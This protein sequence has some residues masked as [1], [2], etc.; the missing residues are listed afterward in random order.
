MDTVNSLPSE[1]FAVV[2]KIDTAS[3]TNASVDSGWFEVGQIGRICALINVGTVAGANSIT[4]SVRRAENASGDNPDANVNIG[5]FAAAAAASGVRIA[6]YD[7]AREKGNPKR[8]LQL[9]IAGNSANAVQTT[10]A[11]LA[12][13]T[14]FKPGSLSNIAAA[15][16]I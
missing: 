13:D 1:R 5:T 3:V 9:R 14:S 12:F 4:V 7:V 11:V 10:A 6:N 8:F 15:T 2:A 16:V